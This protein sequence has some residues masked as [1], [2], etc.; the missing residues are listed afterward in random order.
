MDEHRSESPAVYQLKV[1]LRGSK[2]PIWR[3]LQVAASMSLN[4]LHLILQVIMGWKRRYPYQFDVGLSWYGQDFT[5]EDG[6][7]MPVGEDDTQTPLSEIAPAGRGSFDY[8]YNLDEILLEGSWCV[9]VQVQQ[10]LPAG[11]DLVVPLCLA[12]KRSGPPDHFPGIVDYEGCV[13][14]FRNTADPRHDEARKALDAGFDPDA[15]DIEEIN[16]RLANI[17]RLESEPEAWRRKIPP[18]VSASRPPVGGRW[19]Y[20]SRGRNR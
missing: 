13:L 5:D 16:R 4:R 1:T 18:T 10:I 14:S 3:K 20:G 17:A 8:H 9:K 2:P 12:G 11:P 7:Y 15:F 19:V 6:E